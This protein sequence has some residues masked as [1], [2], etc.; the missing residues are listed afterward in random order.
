MLDGVGAVAGQL[1]AWFPGPLTDQHWS[2]DFL[3]SI[4]EV[5]DLP[6]LLAL[7]V[8]WVRSDA[9]HA[10]RADEL[11]EAELDELVQA[12]LRGGR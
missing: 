3:W 6:I 4:A 5:A 2:G 11:S 1:P 9:H 12:H 7:F 10:D 8:R